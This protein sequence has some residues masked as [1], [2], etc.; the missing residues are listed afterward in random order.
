MEEWRDVVGYEGCYEVSN[1]GRV[2]SVAR[3]VDTYGGGRVFVQG[4]IKKQRPNEKGYMCVSLQH[5]A[6][7]ETRKVHRLVASA[8]IPN[9]DNLP[10]VNHIDCDKANNAVGNLEWCTGEWNREHAKSRGLFARGKQPIRIVMD[11][12]HEFDSINQCARQTGIASKDIR[13]VVGG[14]RKTAHGHTFSRV[15]A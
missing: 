12:V 10:E 3:W 1:L 9:P 11:G 6:R 14:L 4:V 7:K 5:G 13:E 2:R 8:F 15:T